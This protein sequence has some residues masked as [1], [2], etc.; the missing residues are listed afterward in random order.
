LNDE[1]KQRYMSALHMMQSAIAMEIGALGE[2]GAGADAKHNRVGIN[3]AMAEHSALAGLLIQKGLITQDE[4]S[5]AIVE[6]AVLEAES[7]VDRV[8]E[9]LNLPANVSF[10]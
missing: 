2:K 5:E 6:G 8:R 3:S 7:T 1:Q 9:K 10:L 4:Y